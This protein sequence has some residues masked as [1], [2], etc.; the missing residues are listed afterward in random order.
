MGGLGQLFRLFE[1]GRMGRR[2]LEDLVD[3]LDEEDS[4]GER[5][6]R[7]LEAWARAASHVGNVERMI[8]ASARSGARTGGTGA[9]G[10]RKRTVAID[11]DAY[12]RDRALLDGLADER[13]AREELRE[14]ARGRLRHFEKRDGYLYRPAG[15]TPLERYQAALRCRK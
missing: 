1:V 11:W 5:S 7:D 4:G 10:A 14:A 6:I 12:E 9:A 3:E 13:A 2:E 15:S 8:E